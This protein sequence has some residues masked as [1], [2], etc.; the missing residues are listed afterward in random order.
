[1]RK[2]T[3]LIFLKM[4]PILKGHLP[5][6]KKACC[7]AK[8]YFILQKCTQYTVSFMQDWWFTIAIARNEFYIIFHQIKENNLLR[9]FCFRFRFST[10]VQHFKRIYT[11]RTVFTAHLQ[12]HT[13]VS[14][15][16]LCCLQT[17]SE[18]SFA[19]RAKMHKHCLGLVRPE[20]CEGD[21]GV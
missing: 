8:R 17:K 2:Q 4:E 7:F 11:V 10:I 5:R 13:R 15:W 16:V 3:R 14:K 21:Y 18:G 12:S 9:N 1:M 20:D 19:S 6:K